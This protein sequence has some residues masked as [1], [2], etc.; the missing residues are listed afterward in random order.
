MSKLETAEANLKALEK[1]RHA[2][3]LA[4]GKLSRAKF[5]GDKSKIVEAEAEYAAAIQAEK[6]AGIDDRDIDRAT[7][8]VHEARGEQHTETGILPPNHNLKTVLANKK[9]AEVRGAFTLGEVGQDQVDAA[10]A[11]LEAA[12]AEDNAAKL[13]HMENSQSES[14]A[15]HGA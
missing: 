4:N 5:D 6:K 7:V 1:Y 15:E 13:E 11:A 3:D 14:L 12:E 8:A 2:V 9:F 10:R